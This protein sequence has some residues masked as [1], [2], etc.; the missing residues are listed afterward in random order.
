V[1]IL[2]TDDISGKKNGKK[3]KMSKHIQVCENND[4]Q[5]YK[6]RWRVHRS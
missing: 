6:P 2:K 1:K 5:N 4:K 3:I